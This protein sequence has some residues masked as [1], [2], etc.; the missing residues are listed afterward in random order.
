MIKNMVN[1]ESSTP[2]MIEAMGARKR[3]KQ[4]EECWASTFNKVVRAGSEW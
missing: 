3:G 2:E 4:S 1:E